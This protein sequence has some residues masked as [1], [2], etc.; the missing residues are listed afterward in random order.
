[1]IDSPN[2][3]LLEPPYKKMKPHHAAILITSPFIYALSC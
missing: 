2:N 1:M 3:F